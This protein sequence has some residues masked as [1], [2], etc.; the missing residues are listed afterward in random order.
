MLKLNYILFIILKFW[1]N[2][3]SSKLIEISENIRGLIVDFK[4]LTRVCVDVDFNLF[5]HA[6]IFR[7]RMYQL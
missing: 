4:M 3:D 5:F 6:L 7:V 2:G 1:G